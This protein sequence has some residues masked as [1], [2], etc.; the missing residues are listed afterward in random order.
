MCVVLM[1]IPLNNKNHSTLH[2][3]LHFSTKITVNKKHLI[4]VVFIVFPFSS[5]FNNF[6]ERIQNNSCSDIIEVF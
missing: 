1:F 2:D 3:F 6:I 4:F 5:K